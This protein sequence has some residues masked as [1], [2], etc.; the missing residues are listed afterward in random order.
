MSIAT[1][2]SITAAADDRADTRL[3]DLLKQA[4]SGDTAAF[5][6]L[7]A[8]TAPRAFGLALRVIR[9]RSLAEDVTQEAYLKIWH[10]AARFDPLQGHCQGWIFTIVHRVAIDHVRSAQ[11]RSVREDRHHLE[12]STHDRADDDRTHDLA[13]ASIEARRARNAVASLSLPQQEALM[14]AYFDGYTY[15]EV[16]RLLGVPPGT[17]KSRIREGLIHL[18]ES[19]ALPEA[20]QVAP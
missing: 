9:N 5:A 13:H 7:Y 17:I 1:R 6:A 15:S 2:P 8:E 10:T 4:A 16:A 3:G 20:L 14:L 19:M 18:R 12:T 11:S